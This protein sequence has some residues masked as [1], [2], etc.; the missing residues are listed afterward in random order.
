MAQFTLGR[1]LKRQGEHKEA[2]EHLLKVLTVEDEKTAPVLYY[3]ADSYARTGNRLKAIELAEQ[4]KEKARAR[5]QA[6]LLGDIKKLL[7]RLQ[8]NNPQR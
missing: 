7:R 4:A 3:L 8:A 5:L 6:F 1:I 2:I